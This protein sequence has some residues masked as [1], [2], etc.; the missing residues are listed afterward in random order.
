MSL[1]TKSIFL[2]ISS[3]NEFM[4]VFC[5]NI[6]VIIDTLIF[7]SATLNSFSCDESKCDVI[8]ASNTNT[9]LNNTNQPVLWNLTVSKLL[10]HVVIPLERVSNII[11]SQQLLWQVNVPTVVEW[12]VRKDWCDAF[13]VLICCSWSFS[14][15]Q[16][17]HTNLPNLEYFNLSSSIWLWLWW[18]KIKI[19]IPRVI[20]NETGHHF[21]FSDN[22]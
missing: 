4:Q 8:N 20:I 5:C 3:D 14:Q 17:N 12:T 15:E 6:T 16:R 21:C 11:V 13:N 18:T 9:S 22:G 19:L 2:I 10:Q 1:K 7:R